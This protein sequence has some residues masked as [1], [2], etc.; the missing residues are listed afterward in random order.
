MT[1]R[2]NVV[3]TNIGKGKQIGEHE[4]KSINLCWGGGCGWVKINVGVKVQVII[5]IEVWIIYLCTRFE[6]L[7]GR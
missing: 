7:Q 3:G 5:F 2:V 6:D 4:T 1:L